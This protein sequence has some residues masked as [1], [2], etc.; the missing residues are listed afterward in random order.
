MTSDDRSKSLYAER[1]STTQGR[2]GLA[3][4]AAAASIARIL[5]TAK[6]A[7]K[8]SSKEIAENLGVTE[9]RVSQVLSGDGNIHIATL[10]RFLRAMGYEL[11][12]GSPFV[13]V[14]ASSTPAKHW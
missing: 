6:V 14:F 10:A 9:G 1:A 11:K 13:R 7:S 2:L 5:H 12:I 3:A 4:A 8:L